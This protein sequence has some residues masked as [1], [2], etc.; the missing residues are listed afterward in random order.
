MAKMRKAPSGHVLT[1]T[2]KVLKPKCKEGSE[3]PY[4]AALRKVPRGEVVTFA[5]LAVMAT[6]GTGLGSL[7]QAGQ[8]TKSIPRASAIPWWRAVA[9]SR[10]PIR[11]CLQPGREKEQLQRLVKEGLDVELPLSR[12][13][14]LPAFLRPAFGSTSL[15]PQGR[16]S[17]SVVFLHGRAFTGSYY[18]THRPH[19]FGRHPGLRVLLPSAPPRGHMTEWFSSWPVTA[20]ELAAARPAVEALLHAEIRRLG[21]ADR[22]FLGGTSQGCILG[23]DVY[24]RFKPPLAGFLGIAGEWPRCSDAALKRPIC[25]AQLNRPIRLFNDT[26]DTVVRWEDSRKSF[27]SLKKAGFTNLKCSTE[28]GCGHRLG[29]RE[30]LWIRSFLEEIQLLL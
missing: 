30:G 9:T 10:K 14:R 18:A 8:K 12:P 4:K 25:A 17:W 3:D 19:F 1:R 15:E 29:E 6:G 23:L 24:C 2:A 13:V 11:D 7:I 27:A 21:R 20:E 16:H 5:E 26:N 22:V 28:A